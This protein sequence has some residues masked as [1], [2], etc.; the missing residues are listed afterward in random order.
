MD[1]LIELADDGLHEHRQSQFFCPHSPAYILPWNLC[2]GLAK[3]D[4]D[5]VMI[6]R[7]M[8]AGES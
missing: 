7:R 6:G 8:K 2:Q 5:A 3:R 4:R 1:Q